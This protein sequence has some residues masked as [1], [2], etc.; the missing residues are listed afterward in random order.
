[1]ILL[2]FAAGWRKL[3]IVNRLRVKILA[4][5][6]PESGGEKRIGFIWNF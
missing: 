1:L 6:G 2:I 4:V 5:A 3:F